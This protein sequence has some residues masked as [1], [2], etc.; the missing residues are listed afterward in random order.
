MY[1]NEQT[2]PNALQDKK[3]RNE[4]KLSKYLEKIQR[5]DSEVLGEMDYTRA[6]NQ[7]VQTE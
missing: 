3:E 4:M 5:E 6:I 7:D 2:Q 1:I